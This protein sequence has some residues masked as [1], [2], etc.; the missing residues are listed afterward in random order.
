MIPS[1]PKIEAQIR[2]PEGDGVLLGF[3]QN[4]LKQEST[5]ITTKNYTVTEYEVIQIVYLHPNKSPIDPMSQELEGS[6]Q[7]HKRRRREKPRTQ[8]FRISARIKN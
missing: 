5:W 4:K 1:K 8:N 3:S 2:K 6:P 7:I